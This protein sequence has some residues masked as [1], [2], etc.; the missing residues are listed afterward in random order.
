MDFGYLWHIMSGIEAFIM[1]IWTY[2]I[3]FYPITI[4][5]IFLLF[6]AIIKIIKL[7]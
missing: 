6:F 2:C 1:S 7:K 3:F 4:I 5:V